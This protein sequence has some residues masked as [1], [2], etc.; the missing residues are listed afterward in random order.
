MCQSESGC[1]RDTWQ[2]ICEGCKEQD[3][4]LHDRV[5]LHAPDVR[6][7]ERINGEVVQLALALTA[8][9]ELVCQNPAHHKHMYV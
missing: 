5:L 4:G 7:L 9:H 2:C 8:K 1:G 6:H 3:F